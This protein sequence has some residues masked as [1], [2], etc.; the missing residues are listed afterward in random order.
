MLN[1]ILH[2]RALS[3]PFLASVTSCTFTHSHRRQMLWSNRSRISRHWT[4]PSWRYGGISG[5]CNIIQHTLRCTCV[6]THRGK[7]THHTNIRTLWYL[8]VVSHPVLVHN[9]VVEETALRLH[10]RLAWDTNMSTHMCVPAQCHTC[11]VS[12]TSLPI[13]YTRHLLPGQ[14]YCMFW[15]V[16]LN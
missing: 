7:H 14:S 10:S 2:V 11:T 13:V 16:V 15:H 1:C 4:A 6:Y 5:G 9:H 8:T 12:C 3:H